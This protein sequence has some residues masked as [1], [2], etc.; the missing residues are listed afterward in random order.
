MLQLDYMETYELLH[1]HSGESPYSIFINS[2]EEHGYTPLM[3]LAAMRM[4]SNL[5]SEG[6]SGAGRE[7]DETHDTDSDYIK[8]V[9][10]VVSTHNIN[11]SLK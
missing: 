10:L 6:G 2:Q 8:I 4:T 9:K 1:D 5:S 11:L 7:G 3:N